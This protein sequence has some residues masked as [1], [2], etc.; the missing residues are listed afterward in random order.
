MIITTLREYHPSFT[1][2][3]M[4]IDG[5]NRF[6]WVLEDVGRP[7]GVKVPRETC[8]PEGHY[9][10]VISISSR[11]NKPM[12]LLY[13]TN[14]QTVER[15]GVEFTGVRAHGG[16]DVDDTE[17]CPLCAYNTDHNGKVWTRASDDLLIKVQQAIDAGEEVHWVITEKAGV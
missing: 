10:V 11:W 6:C 7:H 12:L 4:Y 15:F 9:R 5:G 1:E 2:S 13:N 17:G 16:N 3:A 14:E 8:I